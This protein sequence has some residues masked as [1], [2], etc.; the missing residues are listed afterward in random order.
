MPQGT[1]DADLAGLCELRGLEVL[2]L[3]EPLVTADG[4]RTV[5]ELRQ[6]RRLALLRAC[7][8]DEGLRRL[9]ALGGLKELDPGGC[10]NVTEEGVARLRKALPGCEVIH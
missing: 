5:S 7:V 9:E 4:L 6:L 2:I 3:I 8:T 1:T 10:P